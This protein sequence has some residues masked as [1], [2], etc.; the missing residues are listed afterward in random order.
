MSHNDKKQEFENPVGG[1]LQLVRFNVPLWQV[2]VSLFLIAIVLTGFKL[3]ER[4]W[5]APGKKVQWKPFDLTEFKQERLH[6]RNILL[7]IHATDDDLNQN[8][9][10]V[11]G[12]ESVQATVYLQRCLAYEIHAGWD[13]SDELAA[14]IGKNAP[15]LAGG[16]IGYWIASDRTPEIA[17]ANAVE[18]D[19]IVQMIESPGRQP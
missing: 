2:F 8:V 10:E 15:K 19:R 7:W 13:D 16:G 18:E 12:R 14:W 17:M 5:I 11:F 4:N 3:Y 9:R 6:R 1:D